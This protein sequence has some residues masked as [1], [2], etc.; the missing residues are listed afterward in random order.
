MGFLF[1]LL[2]FVCLTLNIIAITKWNNSPVIAVDWPSLEFHDK[3]LIYFFS[4]VSY[5]TLSKSVWYC[6]F[7]ISPSMTLWS[8]SKQTKLIPFTFMQKF[9]K[10]ICWWSICIF[11]WECIFKSHFPC[12]CLLANL[13]IVKTD[14]K[15]LEFVF[16]LKMG[17]KFS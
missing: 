15:G 8:I 16:D 4:L 5:R 2:L 6:F 10:C 14:V 13:N 12:V 1:C 17:Q 9:L 3:V 11:C 7:L